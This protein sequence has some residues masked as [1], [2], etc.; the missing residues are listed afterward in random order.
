MKTLL[1][2]TFYFVT[3]MLLILGLYYGKDRVLETTSNVP[4]LNYTKY[5]QDAA[6][7]DSSY[8][9]KIDS[10]AVVV[11]GMLS[12]MTEY[13]SQLQKRDYQIAEK[14]FELD[15]LKRENSELMDKIALSEE[16][17]KKFNKSQ[18]EKKLKDLAKT[19]GTMKPDVLAPILAN[20]PDNLVQIFYDKA[21]AKDRVKIFNALPPDRAGRILTDMAE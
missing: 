3:F 12:E 4:V 19:L 7:A 1:W 14:N 16:N 18:D 17:K 6:L 15:K 5:H 9:E 2:F 10:L 11:E 20:L 13:V 8:T 21:K